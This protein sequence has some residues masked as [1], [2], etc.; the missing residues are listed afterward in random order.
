M[1]IFYRLSDGSYKKERFENATKGNCFL[2]F[3][4]NFMYEHGRSSEDELILVLDNVKDETFDQYS[5]LMKE[6]HIDGRVERTHGGSSAAGFRIVFNMALELNDDE[7]I[8]F[9]EDDYCHLPN[10]RQVLL[11]GLERSHYCCLYTHPDKFI[12][13]SHGGNPLIGEDGAEET[14]VF[15]TQSS[16]WM[17]TNSTTMTCATRVGI[18]REDQDVWKKYTEGDYPH[19]MQ[20]FFELR[21]K[22]RTLVQPIPTKATHCEPRWSAHLFGTGITSWD[23]FLN[24]NKRVD[25]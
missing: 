15:V 12:P 20:I 2:N 7:V 1:K 4:N 8:Y 3:I 14:K 21:N 22:G 17:L 24:Q 18:L 10:S 6:A 11:E 25:I 13:G 9:M 5:L 19:D 16:Y 23:E